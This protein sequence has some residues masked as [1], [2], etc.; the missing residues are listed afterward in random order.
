MPLMNSHLNM[1]NVCSAS[2]SP[3][4]NMYH[5]MLNFMRPE[6]MPTETPSSVQQSLTRKYKGECGII[7]L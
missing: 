3:S 4:S 1:N 2:G 5:R 6:G 7:I